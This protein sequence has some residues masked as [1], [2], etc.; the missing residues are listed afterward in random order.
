MKKIV[1]AF[2]FSISFQVNAQ[3]FWQNPLPQGNFLSD[4]LFVDSI[5]GY[6]AGTFGTILKST[7]G[8]NNWVNITTDIEDSFKKLTFA[9]IQ[10]GWAMNLYNSSLNRT[11]DAGI[12]WEN[13]GEITNSYLNDFEMINDSIG[14]ACG[15]DSKI[16]KT[17]NGGLSW[18]LNETPFYISGLYSIDFINQNVGFCGGSSTYLLKTTDGGNNWVEYSLPIGPFDSNINFLEFKNA[19]FGYIGGYEEDHGLI[20]ITTDGGNSWLRR[21]LGNSI[22]QL[23]FEDINKGWARTGDGIVYYTTDSGLNWNQL[24]DN[25]V[26]FNFFSENNSWAIKNL[27]NIFYSDNGWQTFETQIKSITHQLLED[28]SIN[29]SDKVFICGNQ[30]ILGTIDRGKSWNILYNNL[31]KYFSSLTIKDETEIWAVGNDGMITFSL[32]NGLNWNEVQLSSSWLEDICFINSSKGFAVGTK[33]WSG[34]IFKTNDGGISWDSLSNTPQ[35]E[36]FEKIIFSNDSIGWINSNTG[37]Y[38]SENSGENWTLIKPGRYHTLEIFGNSIWTSSANYIIF[39]NNFGL[40]WNNIQVYDFQNNIVRTIQSISFIDENKGWICIDD[41]RIYKTNDGGFTWTEDSRLAGI[42]IYD[43]KFLNAELGWG[44]GSGGSIIHHNR[45]VN[46][47]NENLQEKAP[48]GYTL[49]QNYP[50]PFNPSTSIQ[51][52]ISSTQFVTLKVYDLLGREVATLVKEEKTAGSYNVEFR[53]QNLELSSG[54]YFYKLQ[55]GEFVESKKMILL[56]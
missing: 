8:G 49:Q 31:N 2:L 32:D 9:S 52:A 34:R 3:W 21:I 35:A 24:F 40:T 16:F 7:D 30:N 28:I 41:G 19:T 56:K 10:N 13:I 14:Y 37:I 51:Y 36:I 45:S 22:Y 26:V 54:I 17:T 1:F 4:I 18:S 15:P 20:L 38:K 50:N 55:A 25:C 48:N 43:I 27:N 6:A 5:N 53:M 39:S 23:Y 29:D 47:I 42:G 46:A 12:T 33:Y 11:T 44:V